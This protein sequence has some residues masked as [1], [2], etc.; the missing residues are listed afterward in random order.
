MKGAI[1]AVEVPVARVALADVVLAAPDP[2]A[3][4]VAEMGREAA[5]VEEAVRKGAPETDDLLDRELAGAEETATEALV[6]DEAEAEAEAAGADVAEA[7]V[8]PAGRVMPFANA[9]W[10]GVLDCNC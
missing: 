6:P 3:V 4:P 9:H 10:A 2:P 7:R 8:K 1:V 5:D